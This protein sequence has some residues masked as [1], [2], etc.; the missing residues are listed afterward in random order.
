MNANVKK[1]RGAILIAEF[2][3]GMILMHPLI[4]LSEWV[5][6]AVLA[7]WMLSAGVE[8]VC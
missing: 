4:Y 8:L 1:R 2:V 7:T 5:S 3:V 6:F